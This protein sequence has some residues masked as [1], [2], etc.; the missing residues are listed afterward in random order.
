TIHY[1]KTVSPLRIIE[2]YARLDYQ[3]MAT[4][5]VL[6]LLSR[7]QVESGI[8]NVL[9]LHILKFKEGELPHISYLEKVLETWFK[10]GIRTTEDAYE[11]VLK[12]QE[13][14]ETKKVS[15]KKKQNPKWVD[16]YLEELK[17]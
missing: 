7:N 10:Q 1:L 5:T 14:V 11:L 16:E 6:E 13:E 3:L 9:L 15:K 17:E 12:R 4:D 8:I 2:N